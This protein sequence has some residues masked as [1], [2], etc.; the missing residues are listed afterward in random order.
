M[1]QK[2]KAIT[3]SVIGFLMCLPFFLF[4]NEGNVTALSFLIGIL[5]FIGVPMFFFGLL[6]LPLNGLG[7]SS[8]SFND[9]D[10]SRIRFAIEQD[11]FNRK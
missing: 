5:C 3:I 6:S 11:K 7:P 1:L 10:V 4:S 8:G 9:Q 2:I